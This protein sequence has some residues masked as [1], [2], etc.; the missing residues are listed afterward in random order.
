[1]VSGLNRPADV[2]D[3]HHAGQSSLLHLRT[4][5]SPRLTIVFYFLPWNR[6]KNSIQ[7]FLDNYILTPPP[8]A[9]LFYTFGLTSAA[10]NYSKGGENELTTI[11]VSYEYALNS[12]SC[13][14]HVQSYI[15]LH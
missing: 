4:T 9:C 12:I 13:S 11:W 10:Q 1:M 7:Y 3:V 8:S 2:L 6:T 15:V 5:Y 14:K